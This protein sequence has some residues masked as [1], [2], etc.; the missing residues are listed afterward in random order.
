M[1]WDSS[2]KSQT[3]KGN[4]FLFAFKKDESIIKCK[5]INVSVEIIG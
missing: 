3:G 4:S 5:C 2:G 1:S